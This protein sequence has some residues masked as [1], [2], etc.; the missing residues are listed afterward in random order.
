MLSLLAMIF[1]LRLG[2]GA[3]PT[4]GAMVSLREQV[5]AVAVQQAAREDA[6]EVAPIRAGELSQSWEAPP[7]YRLS[8]EDWLRMIESAL[9]NETIAN[10][11][12][13]IAT[14]PVHVSMS[15]RRFF[16]SLRFA[17]P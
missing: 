9:A 10:A 1:T 17:T 6:R 4:D 2:L 3:A 15:G 5:Q 8:R 14:Q 16:V 11:A 13:W 7:R 12:V